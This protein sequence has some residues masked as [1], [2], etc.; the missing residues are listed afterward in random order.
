MTTLKQR[1]HVY[2]SKDTSAALDALGGTRGHSKSAIVDAAV[3][4]WFD[5]RAAQPLDDKL[6]VRLDRMSRDIALIHRKLDSSSEVV[7]AFVEHQLTLVAH[8][9]EFS[10]ETVHLGQAR[11]RQFIE[12]VAR[13]LA[14]TA[15]RSEMSILGLLST[16]LESGR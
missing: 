2:L 10:P 14:R 15:G 1:H 4:D 6:A 11:F 13:R 16:A 12:K 9:P 7:G 3:R 8:R 5:R